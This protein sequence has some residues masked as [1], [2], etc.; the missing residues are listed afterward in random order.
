MEINSEA[1]RYAAAWRERVACLDGPLPGSSLSAGE[2]AP[3]SV[4]H[5]LTLAPGRG[6]QC[7]EDVRKR[8]GRVAAALGVPVESVVLARTENVRH[9]RLTLA[10]PGLLERPRVFRGPQLVKGSIGRLGR[11]VVGSDD[12]NLKIWHELGTAATALVGAPGTGRSSALRMLGCS[13]AGTGV[14]NT[15]FVDP[16]GGG[17]PLLRW[18]ARV[19]LTGKDAPELALEL[20]QQI[21]AARSEYMARYDFERLLPCGP[22]GGW[23]LALENIGTTVNRASEPGWFAALSQG[24][25]C[26]LWPVA[27][28]NDFSLATWARER[29]RAMFLSQVVAFWQPAG[30]RVPAAAALHFNPWNLPVDGDGRPVPGFV[31]TGPGWS[32]G[33]PMRLDWMSE[34]SDGEA[35]RLLEG[36]GDGA[37]DAFALQPDVA[38]V[39]ARAIASVLG[40]PVGGRWDVGPD[41]SHERRDG[42]RLVSHRRADERVPAAVAAA[43]GSPA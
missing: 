41:G 37:H 32:S 7:Y 14:M 26:G 38:A 27:V 31:T 35:A 43:V 1:A 13:A 39:D 3:H 9:V 20:V 30:A 2:P 4:S 23:M 29:L 21:V 19:A 5:T 36:G 24:W 22:L 18:R 12:V 8:R 16:N 40:E 17:D 10:E 6:H 33:V 11:T 34:Q 42:D 25:K 28:A 15:L